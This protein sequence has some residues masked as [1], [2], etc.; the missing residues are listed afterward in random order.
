M[1]GLSRRATI[2]EG[3]DGT[4]LTVDAGNFA[5]KSGKITAERLPQQRR[6]A[7]LQLD[8]FALSGIDGVA[9]G[10]GDLVLGVE[11]LKEAASKRAVPLLAANLTCGGEAPFERWREIERDG[12]SIGLVGV[13][14]SSRKVSGCVVSDPVAAMNEAVA[15]LPDV[16]L[17]IAMTQNSDDEDTA[18]AEAVG[19]IDLII[20]GHARL[21]RTN[22][23]ALPGSALQLSSGSRGKK[24]GLA[25]ITLLP[26]GQG[27]SNADAV[28]DLERKQRRTVGRLESAKENV[29]S[30]PDPGAE[31]RAERQVIHYTEELAEIETELAQIRAAGDVLAHALKGRLAPLDRKVSDNAAVD[32]LIATALSEIEALETDAVPPLVNSPFVGSAVCASCHT[33]QYAQWQTT[34]HF[35]AWATLEVEE[36]TADLDCFSCHATGATHPEGP[37][38]PAQVTAALAGVGCED[39]H[40]PGKDHAASPAAG[41][42]VADPPEATCVRCHDGVQDEGRF[43]FSAYRPRVVHGE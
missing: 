40:G 30:P 7:E 2:I 42:M 28:E 5:W 18:L 37:Q 21:N 8:A 19:D 34:A 39:C 9:P 20:N 41:Q 27:F 22:P 33:E 13:L 1:G 15:A 36:R 4:H 26:G 29:E 3:L 32:A 17:L 10:V 12:I 43:D 16:D 6:K 31:R 35:R 24:L 38:H 25:E 23:R 14:A 11:W